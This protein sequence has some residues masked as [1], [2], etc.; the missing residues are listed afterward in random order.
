MTRRE[1][2]DDGTI[3][4]DLVVEVDSKEHRGV[5]RIKR[6][7]RTKSAFEVDY[8]GHYHRDTSLFSHSAEDQ[9]RLHARFVLED[10]VKKDQL[11]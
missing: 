7:D 6:V 5:F 2:L 3:V 11:K 9:M 8:R 1:K 4:E 10:M